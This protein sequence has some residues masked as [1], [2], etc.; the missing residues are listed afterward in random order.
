MAI[1][2]P[3]TTKQLSVSLQ[4]GI[5]P[6]APPPQERTK[7]AATDF[8]GALQ[9]SLDTMQRQLSTANNPFADF[10]VKEFKVDAAVQIK[11]NELGVLQL[12]LADDA[13][14]AQSV[15]RVSLT[16]AAVAKVADET[17]PMKMSGADATPLSDMTWLPPR[18]ITQLAQY[19]VKTAS[20]F[21][22]L[23]ADARFSTQIVSLLKVKRAD[24]GRWA[25]QM[26]LLELPG[27]TTSNVAALGRAGVFAV[28]DLAQL[29]EKNSID[30]QRKASDQFT[31]EMLLHWCGLARQTIV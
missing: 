25:N 2:K 11:V 9:R 30:L 1:K 29:S 24:A 16:L 20:E 3:V 31:K 12:M 18:L 6:A 5:A 4:G 28:A 23:V 15:S 13:M 26:R 27:M 22:G 19:E 10:V 14:P 21:L 8:Y 7:L 17:V